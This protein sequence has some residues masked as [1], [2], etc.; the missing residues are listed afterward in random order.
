MFS[1]PLRVLRGQKGVKV[2]SVP[3]RVLRGQK[4]VKVFSVPLRVLADKKVLT[5][6]ASL[7]LV[8]RTATISLETTKQQERSHSHDHS[9]FYHRTVLPSG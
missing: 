4:G 5:F 6:G 7:E 9:R 3:L 1:V 2:F 8:M